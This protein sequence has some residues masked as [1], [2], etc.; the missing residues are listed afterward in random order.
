MVLSQITRLDFAKLHFHLEVPGHTEKSYQ[1][2]N[3]L[4]DQVFQAS[5]KSPPDRRILRLPREKP[6]R[7]I[8]PAIMH[9]SL[10]RG[11]FERIIAVHHVTGDPIW[12]KVLDVGE[13]YSWRE[14]TDELEGS[15]VFSVSCL[16]VTALP[17]PILN[18]STL[19]GKRR[20]NTGVRSPLC[21][22]MLYDCEAISPTRATLLSF[23][24]SLRGEGLHILPNVD[25]KILAL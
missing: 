8:G 9:D 18:S 19:S 17:Y 2:L 22:R 7:S 20:P 25:E 15:F 21:G 16:P 3:E 14:M 5:G 11:G 13:K 23:L 12:I 6:F 10:V 24:H 1:K 4:L